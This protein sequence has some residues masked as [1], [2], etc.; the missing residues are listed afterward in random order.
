MCEQ[1]SY[2]S[3]MSKVK[4]RPWLV[5]KIIYG[6]EGEFEGSLKSKQSKNDSKILFFPQIVYSKLC[7]FLYIVVK[8][9]S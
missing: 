4:F 8:I 1:L 9:S 2:K 5:T 6:F 7:I 3:Q